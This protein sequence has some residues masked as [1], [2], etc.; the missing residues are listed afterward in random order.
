MK[1]SIVPRRYP[2]NS[3]DV[4]VETIVARRKM[5]I[6]ACIFVVNLAFFLSFPCFEWFVDGELHYTVLNII[7][8]A[9][10]FGSLLAGLL[11]R[12]F[13]RPSKVELKYSKSLLEN[14]DDSSVI[15]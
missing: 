2:L 12:V 6:S 3:N 13:E 10:G 15:H 11:F 1:S 4:V 8:C 9:I 7:I 5:R 14:P